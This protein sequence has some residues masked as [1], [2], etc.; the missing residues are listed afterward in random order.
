MDRGGHDR[1][2]AVNDRESGLSGWIALHDTKRGPSYGGIRV[3]RYPNEAT[4]MLDA[5]RLSRAMTWKCVLAGVRGGGA[6]TV[7]LS[8]RIID[9]PAAMRRLG[10]IV[11]QLGGIYRCGPDAGFVE[12]DEIAI[13]KTTKY[14]AHEAK[15]M[16]PSG[17]A[18]SDGVVWGIRAALESL[19]GSDSL[20]GRTIAIQGLG[21]VGMPP[22]EKLLAA[23]CKVYGADINPE[24]VS[25]AE[26]M[27]VKMVNPP[28]IYE[29]E[30]DVFSP[31]A[32]GGVLHD[33][34]IQRL[35]TKIVAGA[36]NNTLARPG[37][38]ALLASRSILYIPD[39]VLNA[40]A[41]IEGVGNEQSGQTDF[42]AEL[43]NIGT[44]VGDILVRAK[45]DGKTPR[46]TAIMMARE[47][48]SAEGSS[49]PQMEEEDEDS[50]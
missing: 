16:R 30:S 11:E 41:L 37:H 46:D 22:A 34:T 42:S 49:S 27:G 24:A 15:S 17:Q 9:R 48:L 12:A 20:E 4:A 38:A 44:T 39:F 14:F 23:G 21:A 18:T 40:G 29:V 36:A 10:E 32:M 43:R 28:D 13:T 2:I 25:H 33:L 19:E 26:S 1:V 7:V 8:D 47:V 50:I 6:K 5:L 35:K 45:A 3:W 31:C